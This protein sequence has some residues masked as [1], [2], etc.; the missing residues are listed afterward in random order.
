MKNDMKI[1]MI[2]SCPVH[3]PSG[4]FNKRTP[5]GTTDKTAG[6]TAVFV[7]CVQLERKAL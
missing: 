2:R 1:M 7:Q 6:Q 4:W 5:V 3:D